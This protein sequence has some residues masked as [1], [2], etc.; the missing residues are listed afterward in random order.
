MKYTDRQS[1]G[2]SDIERYYQSGNYPIAAT[3]LQSMLERLERSDKYST[4]AIC[5]DIRIDLA[6]WLPD[7]AEE[8]LHNAAED[9]TDIT[10]T[11]TQLHVGGHAKGFAFISSFAALAAVRMTEL[12]QWQQIAEGSAPS[13]DYEALLTACHAS[14]DY[15]QASGH[16]RAT[17]VEYMPM[18][19]G[20]R[21][22]AQGKPDGWTARHALLR[23]DK[24]MF[25]GKSYGR[26]GNWDLGVIAPDASDYKLPTQRLQIKTRGAQPERYA[27]GGVKSISATAF[28]FHQVGKIIRGCVQEFE[29]VPK[30][31]TA[32]STEQLDE[33]SAALHK[34]FT[35]LL[36]EL[37]D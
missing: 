28:G 26:N 30:D 2:P 17:L 24:N 37:S 15:A 12:P 34:E 35:A 31:Q 8:H 16:A 27:R 23:E 19:L 10:E 18:L 36:P 25:T 3:K 29:P 20:A 33:I 1:R 7:K 13:I 21:A 11:A 9:L 6:T 32:Y 22:L 4:I 5:A 14:L